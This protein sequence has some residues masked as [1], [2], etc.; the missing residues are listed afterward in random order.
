[1]RAVAYGRQAERKSKDDNG[2]VMENPSGK[3][4]SN[5]IEDLGLS[6]EEAAL[7]HG[8]HLRRCHLDG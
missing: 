6:S 5:T 7:C 8:Y 2:K 1:M 4:E 3:D